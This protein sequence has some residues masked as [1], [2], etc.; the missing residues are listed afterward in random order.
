MPRPKVAAFVD[1]AV[2]NVGLRREPAHEAAKPPS[3]DAR[4]AS[5]GRTPNP[6]AKEQR[7]GQNG[8]AADGPESRSRN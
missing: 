5:F 6:R 2:A 8:A 3:D 1:V 4:V 7:G